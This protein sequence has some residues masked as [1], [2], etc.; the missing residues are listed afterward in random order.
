MLSD[1]YLKFRISSVF[2][3]IFI[4]CTYVF[5]IHNIL[6]KNKVLLKTLCLQNLTSSRNPLSESTGI[7]PPILIHPSQSTHRKYKNPKIENMISEQDLDADEHSNRSD[8][9]HIFYLWIFIFSSVSANEL[10]CYPI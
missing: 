8:Y 2:Q 10:N 6:I 4:I 9:F 3:A 5:T 1:K 7:S